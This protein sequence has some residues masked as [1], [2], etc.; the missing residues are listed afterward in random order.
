MGRCHNRYERL[1]LPCSRDIRSDNA[2]AHIKPNA[3]LFAIRVAN[4][5][6]QTSFQDDVLVRFRVALPVYLLP[7]AQAHGCPVSRKIVHPIHI[8]QVMRLRQE[9]PQIHFGEPYQMIMR[10]IASLGM[11][12]TVQGDH[13]MML[14]NLSK[15]FGKIA[16]GAALLAASVYL[17]MISVTLAHL[18]FVSGQT[19]FDMRPFGYAPADAAELLGGLGKDGRKYYLTR[20]IPLD[21]LYPA[22]L[23]LTLSSTI[24][25]FGRRM[26]N[27]G[28]VRLG[29]TLAV[30]SALF[31]YLENLG[32]D[33]GFCHC[34]CLGASAHSGLS[35]LDEKGPLRPG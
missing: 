4:T 7:L 1:S 21:T 10:M 17:A 23:A 26:P 25:W 12:G 19:P 33:A 29:V 22:L 6:G 32:S 13:K 18:E 27:S 35:H 24:C 11:C 20:Q 14:E 15:H 9:R 2:G 30:G 8:R 31:D 3:D 5:T 16:I 34:D 28:L